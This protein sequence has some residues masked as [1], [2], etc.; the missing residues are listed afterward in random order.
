MI[1]RKDIR[2]TGYS[3]RKGL[4]FERMYKL[5]LVTNNQKVK[6]AFAGVSSWTLLGWRN[7]TWME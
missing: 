2:C 4:A 6:D 1:L 5:L 7:T 3:I